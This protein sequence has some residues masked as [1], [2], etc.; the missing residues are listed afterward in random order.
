M[1]MKLIRVTKLILNCSFILENDS[2]LNKFNEPIFTVEDNINPRTIG[3][4]IFINVLKKVV[5]LTLLMNTAIINII[6]N[7][8]RITPSVAIIEPSRP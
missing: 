2:M 3:V 8:G 7:E 4:D 6:I 5:F 1:I